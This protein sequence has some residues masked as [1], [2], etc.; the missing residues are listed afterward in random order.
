MPTPKGVS[1]KTRGK[2]NKEKW[3]ALVRKCNSEGSWKKFISGSHLNKKRI[4]RHLEFP[5]DVFDDNPGVDIKKLERKLIS[6]GTLRPINKN[7][8]R[9]KLSR[10]DASL[11]RRFDQLNKLLS[12]ELNNLLQ[13]LQ[14]KQGEIV[15]LNFTFSDDQKIDLNGL[16]KVSNL[17]KKFSPDSTDEDQ[18]RDAKST[19]FLMREWKLKAKMWVNRLK[20]TNQHL[21]HSLRIPRWL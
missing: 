5:I 1:G 12:V 16:K 3:Q 18:L 2:Q 14:T 10:K 7:K 20:I 13:T 11:K 9:K 19:N 8:R 4:A 6:E 21:A 15:M 17:H